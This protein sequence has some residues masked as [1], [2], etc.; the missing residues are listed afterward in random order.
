MTLFELLFH[1]VL[2]PRPDAAQKG[3]KDAIEETVQTAI[4]KSGMKMEDIDAVAVTVGPGLALCLTVGV[5]MAYQIA[6][7]YQKP[8]VR[9]HHMEAHAMVTR[10]PMKPD[11]KLPDFP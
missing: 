10:M 4:D 11:M 7:K 2:C 1:V 6:Q 5:D 8:I 9:I 3:H